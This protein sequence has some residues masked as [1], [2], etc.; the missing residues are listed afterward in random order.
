MVTEMNYWIFKAN[1]RYN[2]PFKQWMLPGASKRWG[3][4]RNPPKDFAV[5][6]KLVFWQSGTGFR[7]IALGYVEDPSLK[8]DSAGKRRFRVSFTTG[9]M[10][11]QIDILAL[12]KLSLF[13]NASF[14][15]SG[16][17][18]TIYPLSVEQGQYLYRTVQTGFGELL[19]A[20]KSIE[21]MEKELAAQ[22]ARSR[23]DSASL[24]KRRLAM[25]AKCRSN[26]L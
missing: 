15:K 13:K 6:N 12:R 7:V 3:A 14:L 16:P 17:T 24:R 10:D 25:A 21:R 20:P 8:K 22:I 18:S 26:V 1:P 19:A 23:R 5:G 9:F 11:G 4:D 2:R